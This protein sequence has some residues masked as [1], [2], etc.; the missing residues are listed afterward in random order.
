[1]RKLFPPA[2]WATAF[3]TLIAF[4]GIGVVDPILPTILTAMHASAFQV[5]WLFT[6]YIAVMALAML[7][8]GYL[9]MKFGARKVLLSGLAIVVVFAALCGMAPNIG[10]LAGLR[11]GWGLGNAFFTSTAL[12][13]IVGASSGSTSV[14]I[15]LYEGA[16]GMG[17]ASGPLLGGFLGGIYWRLP[18]FGTATLMVIAL[19][20]TMALVKDSGQKET[21]RKASDIFIA[22]RH[23]AVMSNALVGLTYSFGFFTILAYSP[24]TL[25]GMS[26]IHLGLT[27]FA[28]GVLVGLS[29]VFVVNWLSPLMGPVRLLD[30]NLICMIVVLAVAGMVQGFGLVVV[31]IF[32]GFFCGVA[33]ALFTTLAME[34][35]PFSRSISSGTYNFVR[36][37]GAAL[38]PILCGLVKDLFGPRVPFW[39]AA[40]LLL[41]G[42]IG[43]RAKRHTIER[44]L[45]EQGNL[46]VGGHGQGRDPARA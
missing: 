22:M 35:S 18:F 10:V 31:I 28:W 39:M 1:M 33:N 25:T 41:V 46:G 7:L 9:S 43:L 12:S 34:V 42:W 44:G 26:G 38:A 21:T 37:A 30:L 27:F 5:E 19:L 40:L 2:V 29:S 11:A 24:L 4:M 32:S 8:S 13:I 17:I 20:L 45:A 3:A 36:W 6:S 14:A 16:L 23:P 15:T